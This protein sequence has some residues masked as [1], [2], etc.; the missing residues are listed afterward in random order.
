MNVGGNL[1]DHD[2][3][4]LPMARTFFS[5]PGDFEPSKTD[6]TPNNSIKI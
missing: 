4:E 2:W 5:D 6:Y 3:L 1:S